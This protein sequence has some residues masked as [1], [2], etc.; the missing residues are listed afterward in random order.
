MLFRLLKLSIAMAVFVALSGCPSP[1]YQKKTPQTEP[2]ISEEDISGQGSQPG[3]EEQSATVPPAP[4][5]EGGPSVTDPG[6]RHPRKF[7]RD[8]QGRWESP[9]EGSSSKE[10]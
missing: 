8:R 2:K 9:S 1:V 3:P 4:P 5:V 7:R 6:S 10:P